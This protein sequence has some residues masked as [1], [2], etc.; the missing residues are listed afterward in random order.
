MFI[1]LQCAAIVD[2]VDD[3]GEPSH[4]LPMPFYVEPDGKVRTWGDAP[5]ADT[6]AYILGFQP[7]PSPRRITLWWDD[8]IHDL[9]R[10]VGMYPVARDRDGGM[11]V[12]LTPVDT[13]EIIDE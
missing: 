12:R 4:Q 8:A 2:R 10:V 1:K 13:A 6:A 3:T 11:S 5:Q 7:A 9:G